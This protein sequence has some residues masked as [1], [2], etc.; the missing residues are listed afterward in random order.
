MSK[1][2]WKDIAELIGI[3]A[4]VASLV[5]VGLELRQTQQVTRLDSSATRAVW[6]MQS[7]EAINEYPEVWIKGNAGG[8]L[9]RAAP[10]IYT[11]LIRNFHTNNGFTWR[12]DQELGIQGAN[13]AAE[14]LA[15]FLYEHPPAR[16]EW[17]SFV[18]E[19][20]ER[21]EA[22]GREE[23]PNGFSRTVRDLLEILDA[24]D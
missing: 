24:R 14:E 9:S 2:G 15:W 17:E 3:A 23:N 16:R 19:L 1:T 13:F 4:I 7:R 5:F 11:N 8:E 6:N 22:F 12:R 18:Q 20:D 21:R 10:D